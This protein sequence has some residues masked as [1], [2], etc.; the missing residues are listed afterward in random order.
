MLVTLYWL[1]RGWTELAAVGAIVAGLI[2]LPV[3]LRGPHRA[4]GGTGRHLF[5]RSAGTRAEDGRPNVL[6]ILTSFAAGIASLVALMWPFGLTLYAPNDTVHGLYQKFEDA[7]RTY[8]GLSIN[9]INLWRK[10]LEPPVH[11]AGLGL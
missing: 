2:K 1:A 7:S 11:G 3:N 10:R 5:G 4:A 9:A 8:A 6:R